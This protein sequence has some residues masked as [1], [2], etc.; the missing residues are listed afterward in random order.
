[1]MQVLTTLLPLC[2]WGLLDAADG[3]Y[4]LG[5]NRSLETDLGLKMTQFTKMQGSICLACMIFVPVWGTVIDQKRFRLKTILAVSAAGW[6]LST[7]AIGLHAHSFNELFLYRFLNTGFLCSKLPVLQSIVTRLAHPRI[8]GA[9]FSACGVAMAMGGILSSRVSAEIAG[10][11]F[12]G[13]PGWRFGFVVLG[14]AS[15]LFSGLVLVLLTEPP[16]ENWQSSCRPNGFW[17]ALVN[18][19]D[20]WASYSFWVIALQCG[21]Y[22]LCLQ[23]LPYLAMWLQYNDF[24]GAQAGIVLMFWRVGDMVGQLIGGFVGDALYSRNAL[25]G[26]QLF[27]QLVSIG[28]VPMLVVIF[29]VLDPRPESLWYFATF[30]FLFG[31]CQDAWGPGVNRPLMSQMASKTSVASFIAWKLTLENC[32]GFFVG[33]PLIT[34]FANIHGYHSSAE[35][36]SSMAPAVQQRNSKALGLLMF[37]VLAGSF[38]AMFI[39]YTALH[40]TFAVDLQRVSSKIGGGDRAGLQPIA[41]ARGDAENGGSDSCMERAPL[42]SAAGVVK[43]YNVT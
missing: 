21:F 2:M 8:H 30:M 24:T 41:C 20:C 35:P 33:P 27:G 5:I 15:T 42:K 38:I 13:M 16:D 36:V 9:C 1:M 3:A 6:G 11:T 26:R 10:E 29:K 31:V 14:C 28:A 19:R 18:F 43:S 34:Q 4:F 40:L 23:V 22:Q 25:H 12:F 7:I 37:N 32:F 17:V 39:C